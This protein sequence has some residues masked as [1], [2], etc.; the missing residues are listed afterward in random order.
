VA[1]IGHSY[2]GL[3]GFAVGET[4]PRHLDA[5]AVSGLIDDLYSGLSYP[6][7]VPNGGFTLLWTQVER[8]ESEY[9]G[10]LDRYGTRSDQQQC[11]HN[12]AT[13]PVPDVSDDAVVNGVAT[14]DDGQWWASH[15]LVTDVANV[16]APTII[17]QQYQDEQTGPQGGFVLWRD[18]PPT[19]PKRLVLTNGAHDT[20]VISQAD[21]LAWVTCWVID[22]GHGCGNVTAA[23][24]RVAL[25]F[26]TTGPG[27]VPF[28]DHVNP[29]LLTRDYPAPATRWT[30]EA[31]AG[32]QY[33]TEPAGRQFYLTGP[34]MADAFG[35]SE[36]PETLVDEL[37]SQVYGP[38]TTVS[39]PDELSDT[40]HFS[41]AVTIAGPIPVSL[42]LRTTAPDTDVFVQ[43][44][45]EAPNGDYQ[46]LQRGL[47]R[48]SY[49]AVD[50]RTSYRI[51]SGPR[52]GQV[53]WWQHPFTNRQLLTPNALYHLQFDI[54]PV[55]AVLR[56]GHRLLVQIYSP[57][58]LDQFDAYGSAQ[59]PA[60]NTIVSD[61]TH[62]SRLLLPLLPH[63]PAVAKQAPACGTVVGERC[64]HPL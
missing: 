16:R 3:T 44:I 46:Y 30:A 11:A 55:G 7:G 31:L 27:N 38:P 41:R 47:L 60:V 52:R 45:D 20:N 14:T 17:T 40:F 64:V 29:A 61:G 15:S 23:S 1:I 25:H 6:G 43:L 5:M 63:Q 53:Y 12:I 10:N 48:A 58:L 32:G 18:L 37:Y 33:V 62:R 8:P 39:G 24:S 9:A 26:E 19:L 21:E 54:P 35:S 42:W 28:Q 59:A 13:R 51:A 56:P 34:G 50:P 22:R 57:P 4:A 2:P 49:R 36:G